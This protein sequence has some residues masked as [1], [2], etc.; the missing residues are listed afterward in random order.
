MDPV[1]EYVVRAREA[2]ADLE[3]TD[4]YPAG[5]LLA[6]L[7]E[8]GWEL[9]LYL[10]YYAAQEEAGIPLDGERAEDYAEVRQAAAWVRRQ[11]TRLKGRS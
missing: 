10:D 6:V 7:R 4:E 1:E 5:D 9:G 8:E 11:K 3:P 2:G